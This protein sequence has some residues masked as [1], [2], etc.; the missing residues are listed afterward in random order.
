[1]TEPLSAEELATLREWA[2]IPD[3]AVRFTSAEARRL[4]ATL[5]ATPAPPDGLREALGPVLDAHYDKHA[6]SDEDG[7][8]DGLCA[9]EIAAALAR[10]TPEDPA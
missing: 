8:C 10:L 1:M 2:A 9:A 3:A 7:H 6:T 4:L 5:D